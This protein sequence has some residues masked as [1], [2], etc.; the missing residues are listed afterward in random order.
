ML[1][2]HVGKK[3]SKP[4]LVVPRL[5]HGLGYRFLLHHGDLPG[6]PDLVFPKLK[7]GIVVHGCFWHRHS[8][9]ARTTTP[10]TRTAY[11]VD[12][13]EQ[14]I[15][16]GFPLCPPDRDIYTATLSQNS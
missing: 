6:T 8:G 7:K 3:N 13:F 4:E 1:M 5:A 9:G 12:R 11:G 2:F 10:K 14:N 15:E 16:P